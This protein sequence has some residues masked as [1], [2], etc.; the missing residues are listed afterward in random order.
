M[1]VA[2]VSVLAVS[3]ALVL[4]WLRNVSEDD[5]AGAVMEAS[6]ADAGGVALNSTFV[7]NFDSPVSSAAVRRC[8]SVEPEIELGLHQ[9][10]SRQQ[11]LVV[12]A[13]PLTE[14]TLY[15]FR[16]SLDETVS[17]W[18]FQ[19]TSSVEV[20][21]SSP[22]D[23]SSLSACRSIEFVF[24]R[25]LYADPERISDWFSITPEV[26]GSF[27]QQG[28]V[29]RFTAEQDFQ[30]GTVYR[31]V[32]KAGLPFSDT[33]A[34]L[35]SDAEVSFEID[36]PAAKWVLSGDN[37]CF[38]GKKPV[39][40]LKSEDGSQ[41]PSQ[42]Q[43]QLFSFT[44]DDYVD[45]LTEICASHPSW[46]SSFRRLSGCGVD[47][48][49]MLLSVGADVAGD[50]T[51]SLPDPPEDGCYL[52]RVSAGGVSR[53]L[54][55][56]VSRLEAAAISHNSGLLLWLHDGR[57]GD[58][59]AQAEVRDAVSGSQATSDAAGAALLADVGEAAVCVVNKGAASLVLPA[60]NCAAADSSP[61]L[62]RYLYL[63]QERCQSGDEL[64]FWGLVQPR[65]GSSLEYDRVTVY[66]FDEDSVPVLSQFSPLNG[67]FFQDSIQLPRLPDGLYR[68]AVWQSGREL[69]SRT[70]AIGEADIPPEYA[71]ASADPALPAVMLDST[72]Y[73]LDDSFAASCSFAAEE[74]LFLLSERNSLAWEATDSG[75]HAGVFHPAN[76]LDC[77]CSALCYNGDGY[78]FC[79]GAPLYLDYEDR[80]LRIELAEKAEGGCT[81]L[82]EDSQGSPVAGAQVNVCLYCGAEDNVSPAD[83]LFRDY[84]GSGFINAAPAAVPGGAGSGKCLFFTVVTTDENGRAETEWGELSADGECCVQV[85]AIS[86]AGR[87]L[88][89]ADTMP[90]QLP[91]AT[92]A[93][94][95]PVSGSRVSGFSVLTPDDP[96]FNGTGEDSLLIAAAPEQAEA[97]ALLGP[98]LAG[99]D[100]VT[101]A[102]A[103]GLLI[104]YSGSMMR[105]LLQGCGFSLLSHQ[106]DDGSIDHDLTTSALLAL[107]QPEEISAHALGKYFNDVISSCADDEDYAICL[108]ALTALGKPQLNDVHML[109]SRE[110]LS[111]SG[112]C[113]LAIAAALCGD[114]RSCGFISKQPLEAE[115]WALYGLALACGGDWTGALSALAHAEEYDG[116]GSCRLC[117]IVTAGLLLS[118]PGSRP[119]Y[120]LTARPSLSDKRS[121]TVSYTVDGADHFNSFTSDSKFQLPLNDFSGSLQLKEGV[122]AGVCCFS[123][124]S[125]ER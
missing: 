28:R 2:L 33:A 52:L 4:N 100:E 94:P 22:Q 122:E 116:S 113:W 103:A 27:E 66:L 92:K 124:S 74:C 77:Y 61:V 32:L 87:I 20:V 7:L 48:G 13:Q 67:G 41:L 78:H 110:D 90:I 101:A 56:M 64:Q 35:G 68:L 31:A 30:P 26:S 69:V 50:G 109:L 75:L 9:G 21:S 44:Q 60:W 117:S 25:L 16:L 96:V 104:G 93:E 97:L 5:V 34:V 55:F 63:S 83:A 82:V 6:D 53:D 70:F 38:S 105:D 54:P 40:R 102:S 19:T 91:L 8:L 73:R 59:A 3:A 81:V 43:A 118:D 121:Y 62:W 84:G 49:R 72:E 17:G 106:L 85:Q 115:E 45:L 46:S 65:D 18:S 89:G 47:K 15:T 99:D 11:V 111:F 29:L 114:S 76:L 42:V 98:A 58:P 86:A 57:T 108:A 125:D 88:A 95:Y 79:A 71:P 10:G 24:D 120:R 36:D 1:L 112:Q 123:V 119:V 51:F 107:L 23:R 37:L 80:R 39:F 12:P 14:D